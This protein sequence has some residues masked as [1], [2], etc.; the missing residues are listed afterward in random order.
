M[1]LIERGD[2]E[3][4]GNVYDTASIVSMLREECLDQEQ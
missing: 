1:A 3:N 2:T 4:V